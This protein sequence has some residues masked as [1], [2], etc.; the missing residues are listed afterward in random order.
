M[1]PR[2]FLVAE[3]WLSI[4][5]FVLALVVLYCVVVL[6]EHFVNAVSRLIR[7]WWKGRRS[8]RPWGGWPK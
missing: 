7:L 3:W 2:S 5:P 1:M 6:T 4:L 8:G